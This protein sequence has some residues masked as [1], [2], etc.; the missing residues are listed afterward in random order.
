MRVGFSAGGMSKMT[1]ANPDLKV[2][3]VQGGRGVE[4]FENIKTTISKLIVWPFELQMDVAM[5]LLDF[6]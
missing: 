4:V 2:L 5:T 3:H 6:K 1:S